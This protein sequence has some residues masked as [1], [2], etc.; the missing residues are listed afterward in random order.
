MQTAT[1]RIASYANLEEDVTVGMRVIYKGME[2]MITSVG[3]KF[4]KVSKVLSTVGDSIIYDEFSYHAGFD[5]V[6]YILED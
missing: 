6:R 4:L 5:D 1:K 3:Y 2:C